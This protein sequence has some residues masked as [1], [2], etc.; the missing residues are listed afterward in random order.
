MDSSSPYSINGPPEGRGLPQLGTMLPAG[1]LRR[2]GE[3]IQRLHRLLDALMAPLLLGLIAEYRLG[4]FSTGAQVLGLLVGLAVAMLASEVGLYDS[5][6]ARSLQNLLRRLLLLW[7]LMVGGVSLGLYAFKLGSIYSRELLLSWY[8]LYGGWL[9]FSHISSRQALR[10]LRERGHNKRIDG[11]IGSV[12]GF[13][14]MAEQ[15]RQS[16]WLG[17]SVSPL[18][19]WP[20]AEGP[21]PSQLHGLPAVLAANRPDQWLVEDPGNSKELGWIL[22]QLENHTEPVLLLPRWLQQSPCEPVYCRLG[23]VAALQLWGAEATPM[24]L[25]IK[26]GAD[27]L[28]STALLLL[29]SPLLVAIA[30]AVRLESPGPALF[31]QTRYGL[32]GEPF[33]CLKFRTMRVQENGAVVVQAQRKDPRIT[34]IGALLRKTNLDELPQLLNVIQGEMSLV[35]PRPH[36]AA[37]NEHYRGRVQAY[38]RRH[39]L[40]PGIT[41]WAQVLGLRGA[42]ETDAKMAAR[43]QADL[44]YIR[45]WSLHLDFKILLMTVLRG[46]DRN[47]Y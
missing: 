36:A 41:G 23:P 26:H 42:T 30:V 47:A 31:R 34:R 18:L 28:V 14:K 44:D 32:R 40:R 17:H 29:L 46:R 13:R 45:N 10:L 6:R 43:V 1:A 8:V 20:E 22:S 5:F 2:Y 24:E 11:Y 15:M 38:M 12:E 39:A 7:G 3:D 16:S 4:S 21:A 33:S 35:G 19:T 27:L 9:V 37:H 25:S